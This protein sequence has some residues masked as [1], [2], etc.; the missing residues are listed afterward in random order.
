MSH[1]KQVC[2]VAIVSILSL[3]SGLFIGEYV[4]SF[5]SVIVSPPNIVLKDSSGGIN[6]TTVYVSQVVNSTRD[7]YVQVYRLLVENGS[8]FPSNPSSGY[9]FFRTDWN[10]LTFHNGTDWNN[11][12]GVDGVTDYSGLTNKPDLTVFLVKNLTDN[13]NIGGSYGVYGATWVNS[14]SLSLS[15][16]LWWNSQNRTDVVANPIE[17]ASYVIDVSGSTYR[18]KNGTTGQFDFSSTN[19]SAVINNAMGNLTGGRTW[20]EKV[21]LKGNFTVDRSILMPNY[22]IL[23][24]QGKIK[25]A[26]YANVSILSNNAVATTG[27]TQIEIVGGEIDGNQN[28]ES[29]QSASAI[30]F[31]NCSNLLIHNVIVHDSCFYGIRV[32]SGQGTST[33]DSYSTVTIDKCSFYNNRN[34]HIVISCSATVSNC[35]FRSQVIFNYLSFVSAQGA[36]VRDCKFFNASQNANSA[37]I[38]I[39]YNSSNIIIANNYFSDCIIGINDYPD[40]HWGKD[41]EIIGNILNYSV[42]NAGTYGIYLFGYGNNGTIIENNVV[43]GYNNATPGYG[44]GIYLRGNYNQVK[45]NLIENNRLGFVP[46]NFNYSLIT[47]NVIQGNSLWNVYLGFQPSY[48][49]GN[50]WRNNIGLVTENSG[51]SASCINGTW[52]AHGLAAAPEGECQLGVNGSRLINATCYVLD[53]TIIAQ[54]STHVQIEFLANNAGTFNPVTATEAKTILWYFEYKP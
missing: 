8:S 46:Y 17:T 52:I 22:T 34:D 15:G 29:P 53:P 45:N 7:S 10:L 13:W 9:L 50:I 6:V 24:I 26:N 14:T 30:Y 37:G 43:K 18:M 51:S 16:Q 42:A 25:L 12:T 41:I 20:K 49:V 21:V 36:I 11:C 31:A 54:N 44:F 33:F 38:G 5:S 32:G 47:G 23:E 2:L 28:N 4:H 3:V 40:H 35:E 48:C 19:A 27:N 1:R 39:E